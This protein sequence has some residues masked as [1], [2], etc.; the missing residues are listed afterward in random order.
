M[1]IF[2]PLIALVLKLLYPLSRRYYV[3]H[4]LF[5]VHVQSFWF[6]A[7]FALSI[8]ESAARFVPLGSLVDALVHFVTLAYLPYYGYRAMRVVYGQGRFATL[9]KFFALMTVYVLALLV[10][11][12]GAFVISALTY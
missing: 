10:L 2:L 11:F 5:I 12:V 4:L 7:L 1:F 3:E 8:V 9:S 6:L